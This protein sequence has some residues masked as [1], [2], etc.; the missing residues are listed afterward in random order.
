MPARRGALERSAVAE[1]AWKEH[2]PHQMGGVFDSG[3]GQKTQG[4]VAKEAL[5][6]QM[7]LA[8]ERFNRDGGLELPDCWTATLRQLRGAELARVDSDVP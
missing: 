1:H 5:H 3:P 8:E 2:Q 4:A 7:T 6:A